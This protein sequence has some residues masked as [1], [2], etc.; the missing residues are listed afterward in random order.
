[1]A[2]RSK[3]KLE[4]LQGQIQSCHPDAITHTLEVDMSS[5]RSVN[6]AVRD[7]ERLSLPGI[8]VLICNAGSTSI[9]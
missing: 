4:E 1:M 6:D 2:S 5:L 7:F 3:A 9:S 8:N